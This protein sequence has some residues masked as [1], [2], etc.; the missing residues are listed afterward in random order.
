MGAARAA[1]IRCRSEGEF[2]LEYGLA[3]FET[4]RSGGPP[5]IRLLDAND[6][7]FGAERPLPQPEGEIMLPD[8]DG[9][10]E[11][12]DDAYFDDPSPVSGAGFN[13]R[14]L[15]EPLTVL[16]TRPPICFKGTDPV[17]EAMTAMQREHRGCVLVTEDGTQRTR[18]TGIFTER[19][20]LLRIID[21]GRHPASVT[22]DEVM[23]KDPECLPVDSP[24]AWVLNKMSVGGFRHV[25]ATDEDGRPAIIVSVRD[26]VQF[27]VEAF[28]NEILNLPP[29]G[30]ERYRTRD[31]A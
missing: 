27:L 19:D 11:F 28:P 24:I 12:G 15:R 2:R 6:A 26:V 4:A 5:H 16:P 21:R 25:P 7:D 23:V 1:R 30:V 14:L 13:A 10:S 29:E 8:L 17:S 31:G 22:I 9:T 18:L 3:P 20:I